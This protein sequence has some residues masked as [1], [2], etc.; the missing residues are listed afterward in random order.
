MTYNATDDDLLP[1]WEYCK[2]SEKRALLL[3]PILNAFPARYLAS[4][5]L[6]VCE[7][8]LAPGHDQSGSL[9]T[10]GQ[11]LLSAEPSPDVNRALLRQVWKSLMRFR[12][13]DEYVSCAEVWLEFTCRHFG[14][15]EINTLLD[16]IIRHVMPDMVN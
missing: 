2:Q 15:R 7:I 14:T 4:N 1:L 8:V 3:T 13:L 11:R 10:F 12:S 16:D 5:A 6:E 9:K